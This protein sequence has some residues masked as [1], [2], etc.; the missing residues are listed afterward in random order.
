MVA[1]K[2][3]YL[4]LKLEAERGAFSQE[5]AKHCVYEA[6]FSLLGEEGA[7]R[8]GLQLK[9]FDDSG[10]LLVLK[11]ANNEVDRVI[12]ALAAKTGF[13]GAACALRLQR[14]SGGINRLLPLPPQRA[15]KP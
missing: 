6:V 15:G 9:E 12:A 10:Q 2:K 14:I 3:R 11:C 1:E 7:S 4:L 8:A 13:R 5:E